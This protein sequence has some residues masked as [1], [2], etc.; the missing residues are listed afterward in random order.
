MSLRYAVVVGAHG[1]YRGRQAL[2][3]GCRGGGERHDFGLTSELGVLL[4]ENLIC[5]NEVGNLVNNKGLEETRGICCRK[6]TKTFTMKA[7]KSLECNR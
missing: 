6:L 5:G 2:L 7:Q 1:A 3:S 4:Q